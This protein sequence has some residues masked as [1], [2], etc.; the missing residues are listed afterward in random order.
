MLG[1]SV[2]GGVLGGRVAACRAKQKVLERPAVVVQSWRFR[3]TAEDCRFV[4]G[5]GII[6]S[7]IVDRIVILLGHVSAERSTESDVQWLE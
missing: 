5:Y 6:R 2:F 3:V 4:L 7:V 1:T